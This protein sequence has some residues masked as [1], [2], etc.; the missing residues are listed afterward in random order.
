MMLV[1]WSRRMSRTDNGAVDGDHIKTSTLGCLLRSVVI[2]EQREMGTAVGHDVLKDRTA[3]RTLKCLHVVRH[4][5]FDFGF[6]SRSHLGDNFVDR[7]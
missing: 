7:R 1:A 2:G 5:Q 4:E 6:S 3:C